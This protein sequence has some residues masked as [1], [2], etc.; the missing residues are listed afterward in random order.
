MCAKSYI[1]MEVPHDKAVALAACRQPGGSRRI[2]YIGSERKNSVRK[3][4][5]RYKH[6]EEKSGSIALRPVEIPPLYHICIILL[7]FGYLAK[8]LTYRG[9]A[10]VL[11]LLF[12]RSFCDL[13]SILWHIKLCR[14][15][16]Q[17][18]KRTKDSGNQSVARFRETILSPKVCLLYDSQATKQTDWFLSGLLFGYSFGLKVHQL[19]RFLCFESEFTSTQVNKFVQC[20]EWCVLSILVCYFQI[21]RHCSCA[22]FHISE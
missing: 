5:E 4:G 17:I 14:P 19:A 9:E 10:T 7:S 6:R 3:T 18:Q 1:S 16:P 21:F 15:F 13:I 22:S 12:S 11:L 20:V 8:I 2:P